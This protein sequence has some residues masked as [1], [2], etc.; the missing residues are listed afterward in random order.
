MTNFWWHQSILQEDINNFF[1]GIHID[2]NMYWISPA[3]PWNSTIICMLLFSKF[4]VPLLRRCLYCLVVKTWEVYHRLYL[5]VLSMIP[6]KKTSTV[7]Q[8][9]SF[10]IDYFYHVLIFNELSTYNCIKNMLCTIPNLNLKIYW[11]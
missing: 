5:H 8:L 6:K 10:Y 2:T 9:C 1:K 11:F 3:T 7:A 4:G